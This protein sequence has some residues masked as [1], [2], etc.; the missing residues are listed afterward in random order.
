[1]CCSRRLMT[2]P[3][4]NR[5]EVAFDTLGMV[6]GTAVMGKAGRTQGDSLPGS[7]PTSTRPQ[8]SLIWTIPWPIPHAILQRATTR[9]VYDLFAYQRTKDQPHLNRRVAYALARETHDADLAPASRPR[10]STLSPIPTASGAR[11]RRRS[12]RSRDHL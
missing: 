10:S 12:R 5:R 4:G 3:N 11:S 1:M 7:M 8:P 2:D 6:V 9:M